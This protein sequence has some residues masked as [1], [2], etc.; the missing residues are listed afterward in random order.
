VGSAVNGAKIAAVWD[1]LPRRGCRI[2]PRVSTGFNPRKHPIKRFAL[3]GREIVWSKCYRKGIGYLLGK[4]SPV[5]VKLRRPFHD[6]RLLGLQRCGQPGV[7][8][9]G[10]SLRNHR[11]NKAA[12]FLLGNDCL[13]HLHFITDPVLSLFARPLAD[14][15]ASGSWGFWMTPVAWTLTGSIFPPG[16]TSYCS[17]GVSATLAAPNLSVKSF[18]KSSHSFGCDV[19]QRAGLAE[20]LER[21]DALQQADF[22]GHFVVNRAGQKGIFGGLRQ[23]FF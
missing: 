17:S 20:F 5:G 3:K 12:L 18:W 23:H 8:A 10:G 1:V 22:F 16:S 14:H 7:V 6:Q 2:Q 13:G 11:G 21:F 15:C 4:V 9:L 19:R